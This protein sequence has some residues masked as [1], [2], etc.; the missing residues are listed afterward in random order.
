MENR[1]CG[2]RRGVRTSGARERSLDLAIVAGPALILL[3]LVSGMNASAE[4][5]RDSCVECHGKT[6]FLVTNKK[7]Y[8]YFQRWRSSNH[9]RAGVTCVD[10]HGGNARSFDKEKAHGGDLDA[11]QSSSAVNFRNIPK[12]C[13]QCHPSI[14][15]AFR[16]SAHFEH[17]VGKDHE[18]EGPT[19]VTCHG[20][21]NATVL[22]AYTVE[23]ACRKC[24]NEE[25]QRHPEDVKKASTLLRSFL[26]IRRH[27]HYIAARGDPAVT[28]PFLESIDARLYDLTLTWHTFDLEATSEKSRA[29]LGEL[30]AKREDVAAAGHKNALE[31]RGQLPQ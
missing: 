26:A 18:G 10:C 30:R 12:T 15:E 24:H 17:V 11:A 21:K 13:G 5:A 27:Y 9:T 23:E 25:S 4:E 31:N 22:S 19:C 2:E 14:H 28:K 29:L 16:E 7:L 8:S 6:S 3:F 1:V 20:S